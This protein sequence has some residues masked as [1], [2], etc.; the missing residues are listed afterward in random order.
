MLARL[1]AA[2]QEGD[3][4]AY[5]RFLLEASVVLRRFLSR[6]MRDVDVVEDVLQDTLLSIH[7]ARHTFRPGRP[8]GPWLY[9]ICEHRMTDF[10]RR[11]RRIA[12]REVA[13]PDDLASRAAA[14]PPSDESERGRVVREALARPPER[15]RQVIELLKV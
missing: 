5:E 1:L 10:Y 7:R 6:R 9:A 12:R 4:A 14:A 8:L 15:Q 2:A 3:T 11:H 13:A